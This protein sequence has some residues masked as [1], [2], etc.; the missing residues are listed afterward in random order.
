MLYF[1]PTPFPGAFMRILAIILLLSL[2]LPAAAR[3]YQWV[4]PDTDTPQLSGKPPTWYRSREGG[5][6]V[7][8]YDRSRIIDDTSVVVSESEREQLRQDALMQAERDQTAINEK[9]IEA[10]RMQAVLDR[11]KPVEEETPAEE[12]PAPQPEPVAEAVP[13]NQSPTIDAMRALIEQWDQL[14]TD[15]ARDVANGVGEAPPP[16]Q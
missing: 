11:R 6:R 8:V 15:D 1:S 13:E 4:E 10:K 14:R 12:V 3:M 5:P 7:I 16:P 2:S 9:L